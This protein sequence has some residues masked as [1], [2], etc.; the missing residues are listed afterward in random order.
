MA[1]VLVI[2]KEQKW[3]LLLKAA[4]EGRYT[5]SFCNEDSDALQAS[6][7]QTYYDLV[8]YNLPS[9]MNETFSQTMQELRKHL[10]F[11]PVVVT[12]DSCE[13]G[14]VVLAIKQGAYDFVVKPYDAA[15]ISL[16]L[17]NAQESLSLKNEIN[18]LRREQDVIY[19]MSKV[20]ALSPAMRQV[21]DNVN[22]FAATDS[23]V[24]MTGETGTGK[25]MLAGSVHFNSSRRLKPFVK[26]NCANIQENLLES[27]LFGHEK[28][29]FT[30]ADKMR[31]GRFEQA[32]GG[33]ILLDEI[34]EMSFGLQ[35]KLLRILEEKSFERLGGNRTIHVDTRVIAATHRDLE[36]LVR[37]KK[38]REDLFYRINVLPIHLPPLRERKQC[39]EPLANFLLKKLSRTLHKLVKKFTPEVMELIKAYPWPGN[40]RQLANTIERAVLLEDGETIQMDNFTLLEVETKQKAEPAGFAKSLPLA[41]LEKEKILAALEESL[42]IQKDAAILLGV[43][44]RVLN[45]KIKKFAITHHRWRKN[46]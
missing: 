12:S 10:P 29:S 18:Y 37:Q 38:F 11:S 28:G 4:C 39:L 14:T 35:A 22:K 8:L 26:I 34:G 45:H 32:N 20:I 17:G 7:N 27:E 43:S 19:E 36:E 40:I 3:R 5:L 42:W 33:S 44:P 23:T 2:E 13:V 25:S 6:V 15:K 30:G 1:T 24:L 41:E 31:V 16:A 9:D 21:I 46:T